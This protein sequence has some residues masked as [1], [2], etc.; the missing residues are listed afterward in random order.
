[1][2]DFIEKLTYLKD[3]LSEML[4]LADDYT[5]QM[6]VLLDKG[7]GDIIHFKEDTAHDLKLE[8]A[9]CDSR[10][11]FIFNS[12]ACAV[13]REYKYTP[14]ITCIFRTDAEQ[15]DIYKDDPAYQAKKVISVH[16]VWRGIDFRSGDMP[17]AV[18]QFT[19]DYF[20][21]QVVY[22]GNHD[23]L[24]RHSVGRGDHFHLQTDSDSNT[25]IRS[26]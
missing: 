26:L 10:L 1:M 3:H 22:T 20:I 6:A 9:A 7:N 16:Q 11:R 4:V 23:T 13:Y 24:I 12:Y 19:M 8:Y 21:K 17:E 14:T 15:D 25:E 18:A 2:K 5:K